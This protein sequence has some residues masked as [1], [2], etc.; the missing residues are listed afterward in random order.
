[1]TGA[2]QAE[3]LDHLDGMSQAIL[4][5]TTLSGA[6]GQYRVVQQF[7]AFLALVVNIGESNHV[8]SRFTNRVVASILAL[9]GHTG[10]IVLQ[11][12]FSILR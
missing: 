9:H 10:N 5:Y 6:P 8:A 1:M 12:I 7:R 3:T 11:N 4:Q 2:T